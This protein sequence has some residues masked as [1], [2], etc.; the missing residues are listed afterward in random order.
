V[1]WKYQA[2]IPLCILGLPCISYNSTTIFKKFKSSIE[3]CPIDVIP[4]EVYPIEAYLIGKGTIEVSGC[5]QDNF[6]FLKYA[7]D[8]LF[9]L[10]YCCLCFVTM[11]GAYCITYWAAQTCPDP[12]Q[13]GSNYGISLA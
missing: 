1:P 5:S 11:G 7:S 4:I 6:A 10:L 2:V 13:S 9:Y 12:T 8:V 3:I